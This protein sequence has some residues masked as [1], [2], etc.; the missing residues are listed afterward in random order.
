MGKGG[1]T[2]EA[3]ADR[4]RRLL[5]T[6]GNADGD[7][8]FFLPPFERNPGAGAALQDISNRGLHGRNVT[9][10]DSGSGHNIRGRMLAARL[11]GND[12]YWEIADNVLLTPISGGVDAAFSVGCAFNMRAVNASTKTL[13]SKYDNQTPNYEWRIHLDATERI[14][15][16]LLDNNVVNGYRGRYYNTPLI[17]N[18]W[19]VA[20]ATYNGVGG[21]DA[22]DGITVYL[23]DGASETWLGAVDD[24]DFN[25]AGVYVD[26]EDT[27]QPVM[28]GA[29]D[30]AAGPNP[31]DFWDGDIS[32]P[33]MTRRELS[34]KEAEKAARLMVSLL[35]L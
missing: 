8:V 21:T 35:E 29:A 25:G 19:Y 30:T 7:L 26:M 31:D 23:W 13:I 9:A 12:E 6:L 32:M 22:A 17:A 2:T 11:N 27:A 20:I 18:T 34:A 1:A 5:N 28:I 15:L 10:Y 33:F 24:T 3:G 4:L 16:Q 14:V